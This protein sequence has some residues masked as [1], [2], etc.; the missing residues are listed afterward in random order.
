MTPQLE[1]AEDQAAIDTVEV[2]GPTIQGEGP[3]LGRLASFVRLAR[4]N[5]SCGWCDTTYSWKPGE[6]APVTTWTIPELVADLKGR[7]APLVV[8]TG[9]EPLLQ[10]HR[11]GRLFLALRNAGLASEVETN[12]TIPPVGLL[13]LPDRCNVSVKLA[14]S[15]L[16]APQRIRPRAIDGFVALA[17]SGKAQVAWKFVCQWPEDLAEIEALV[18]GYDLPRHD[19]W[20]MP[21]GRSVPELETHL[22]ALRDA[23]IARGWNLTTRL[24][25]HLWG[26]RRGV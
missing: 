22:I 6:L 26:D 17:A 10:K 12:G 9:G 25:I 15:G 19:I 8:V 11:L 2:F 20:V 24:H 14:H 16:P 7:G 13:S 5:L 4:C 1:A 21:E 18:L 3:S 23:V